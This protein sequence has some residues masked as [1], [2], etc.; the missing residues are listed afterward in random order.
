MSIDFSQAITAEA[1]AAAAQAALLAACQNAI[2]EHVESVAKAKGYN[3]AAHLASYLASTVAE[4]AAEAAAF[5]AWRDAVWVAAVATLD[6]VQQGIVPPP[7][8]PADVIALLP[9]PD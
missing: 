6:D 2:D 8:S 7:A 5:V 4:W 1:K 3:G 9:Q